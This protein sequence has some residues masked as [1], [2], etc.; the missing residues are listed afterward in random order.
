MNCK[1]IK[2]HTL[3]LNDAELAELGKCPFTRSIELEA[4]MCAWEHML[5]K[6]DMEKY[7]GYGQA[8]FCCGNLAYAI[9]IGY[10][11]ANI[12]DKLDGYAYDWEFVPWFCDTCVIWDSP[13]A[14]IHGYPYLVDDWVQ[15]C[16][17]LDFNPEPRLSDEDLL[18]NCLTAFNTIPNQSYS[19]GMTYDLAEALSQRLKA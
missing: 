2:V 6:D 18:K 14:Y 16:R 5:T 17:A 1:D 7:G 13:Q 15:K 9:H 12:D 10:C 4:A 8:R 11:I 3:I 19:D